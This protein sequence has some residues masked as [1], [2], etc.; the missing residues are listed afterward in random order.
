MEKIG[1]RCDVRVKIAS[2]GPCVV[3]F[4]NNHAGA[5]GSLED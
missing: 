2:N 1:K 3:L 4:I 5:M